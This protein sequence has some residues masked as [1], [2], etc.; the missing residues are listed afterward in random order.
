[1]SQD[2]PI[3][4]H[5]T[6]HLCEFVFVHHTSVKLGKEQKWTTKSAVKQ[7]PAYFKKLPSMCSNHEEIKLVIS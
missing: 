4:N 6:V 1:M 3:S 5:H 7:V 2:I